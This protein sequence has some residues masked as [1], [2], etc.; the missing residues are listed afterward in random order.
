MFGDL[1]VD[2]TVSIPAAE[3]S[4]KFSH[5]GGPG[6]QGV[7]TADSKVELRFNLAATTSIPQH[8]KDRALQRLDAR[9]VD[10]TLIVTSSAHRNQL[11][12]RR[13]AAAKLAVL[14][15]RAIAPSPPQRRATRPSLR[16]VQA[17]LDT[18]RRH[19]R[20]KQNRRDLED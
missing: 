8:L 5:S 9:L 17:R 12:N 20:L 10:G 14:L 7:N 19:G 15:S 1:R 13:V 2:R 4:W 6:G 18:K 3:L 16:S 11:D